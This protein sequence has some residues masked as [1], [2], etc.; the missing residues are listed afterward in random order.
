MALIGRKRFPESASQTVVHEARSRSD[1]SATRKQADGVMRLRSTPRMN[2]VGECASA[3]RSTSFGLLLVSTRTTSAWQFVQRHR[4]LHRQGDRRRRGGPCIPMCRRVRVCLPPAA[5]S[6]HT[7][8]LCNRA[9]Q[10]DGEPSFL[11]VGQSESRFANLVAAPRSGACRVRTLSFA[12][13]S[14]A[15][16]TRFT[17]EATIPVL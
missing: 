3:A 4:N 6:C 7:R 14:V 1:L 15:G 8:R 9:A 5:G 16:W 10:V 17:G 11:S 12:P 13:R 2:V